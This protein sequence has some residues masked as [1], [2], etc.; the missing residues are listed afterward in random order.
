M[1]VSWE[2]GV[3][4]IRDLRVQVREAVVDRGCHK[5]PNH[6]PRLSDHL[7]ADTVAD[8]CWAGVPKAPPE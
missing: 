3:L 8:R 7:A 5:P 6:I 4:G 2:A 1:P